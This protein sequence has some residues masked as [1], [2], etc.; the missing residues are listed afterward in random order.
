MSNEPATSTGPDTFVA[1][2]PFWYATNLGGLVMNGVIA[3][4]TQK[5]LAK[6]SFWGGVA[7]HV[8]EAAYAYVTAS[9]AGFTRSAPKWALQ[10]LAVGFPSL[11]ALHAAKQTT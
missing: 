9:R 5:R 6:L 1:V 2:S 3:A 11:R 7:L 8:G 10:T 4:A